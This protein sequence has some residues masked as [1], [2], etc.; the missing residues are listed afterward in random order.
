MG[1]GKEVLRLQSFM[2]SELGTPQML[3]AA[4]SPGEQR[5][6][7]L[8]HSTGKAGGVE[9][10]STVARKEEREANNPGSVERRE[11][12]AGYRMAGESEVRKQPLPLP[13]S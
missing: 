7:W 1:N 12:G 9:E 11:K 2:G 3:K 13:P 10:N 8:G 6:E 5:E 4:S